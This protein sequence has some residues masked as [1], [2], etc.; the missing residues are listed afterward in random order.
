MATN[1]DNRALSNLG[2]STDPTQYKATFDGLKN[3][4]V[5][6]Q[7]SPHKFALFKEKVIFTKNIS[8]IALNL[9]YHEKYISFCC[10][11]IPNFIWL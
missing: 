8:K 5:G 6:C 7:K 11:S 4:S 3:K 2:S 1:L 10:A 9:S